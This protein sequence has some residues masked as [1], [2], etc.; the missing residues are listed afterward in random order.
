MDVGNKSACRQREEVGAPVVR[1]N[2]GDGR[3]DERVTPHAFPIC[4]RDVVR[5]ESAWPQPYDWSECGVRVGR[6]AGGQTLGRGRP[7]R[8]SHEA[9]PGYNAWPTL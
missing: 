3:Q 1:K 2:S 5:S 7:V 8:G 9:G 6:A 4:I